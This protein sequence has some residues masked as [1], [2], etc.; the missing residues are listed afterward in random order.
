M[1]HF[2]ATRGG[3][4]SVVGGHGAPDGRT[5]AKG[6]IEGAGRH[7]PR[8]GADGRGPDRADRRLAARP[9]MIAAPW[10]VPRFPW[11]GGDLQTLRNFMRPPADDLL[12]PWPGEVLS[13]PMKD[14]T[15]DLL[16]GTLHR[17]LEDRGRSLVL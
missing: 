8:T 17:P 13:F 2:R 6:A 10:F 9:D 3:V 14:D 11:I 1:S 15:G 16:L 12:A 5:R 7:R 4:R